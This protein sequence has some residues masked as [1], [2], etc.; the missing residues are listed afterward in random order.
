[1]AGVRRLLGERPRPG[2]RRDPPRPGHRAGAA[3]HLH[4]AAQ[5]AGLVLQR[6]RGAL[7]PRPVVA[8]VRRPAAG[9]FRAATGSPGYHELLFDPDP[10]VH[11][12]A[13][14]AWTTWEAATVTLEFS[15]A[16]VEEF[17]DPAFALAFARIENHYFVHGG[18]LEEGQLLARRGRLRGIPGVIVQGRYDLALSGHHRR[19]PAP[20]LAGGRLP[21]GPGRAFG[22]RTGDRR[23]AGG[24]HR[25]VRV[26]LRNRAGP[27]GSR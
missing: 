1:M 11:Q 5:R 23:R 21:G 7:R 15:P 13:G 2:L 12:P 18:W 8:L 19:R 14:V 3:R 6:R 25:P 9:R 20:R 24:G 4:A 17:S 22:R 26:P 27:A 16:L 10:A